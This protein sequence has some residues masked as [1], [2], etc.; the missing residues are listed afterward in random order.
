MTPEQRAQAVEICQQEAYKPVFF[1]SD[2]WNEMRW[3]IWHITMPTMC[4]KLFGLVPN[5]LYYRH[6]IMLDEHTPDSA[7]FAVV[8]AIMANG[9]MDAFNGVWVDP[10]EVVE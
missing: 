6:A 3:K 2:D 9:G 5:F 7:D 10:R 4:E 1:G 8:D